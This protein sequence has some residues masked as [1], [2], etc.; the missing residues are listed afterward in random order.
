M[1]YIDIRIL[2]I[3]A[4]DSSNLQLLYRQSAKLRAFVF[5]VLS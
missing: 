2:I 4:D 5:V 3:Q 1:R